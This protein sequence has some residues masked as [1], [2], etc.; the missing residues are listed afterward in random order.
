MGRT[1]DA[2][3]RL[4]LDLCRIRV[5]VET[6]PPLLGAGL[7]FLTAGAVLVAALLALG[8]RTRLRANR[9]EALAAAA[10]GT[11]IL[12]GGIGLL[13][14]AEQEV[15]SGLAALIIASVPWVVVLRL[16]AKQRVTCAT[17]A[18]GLVRRLLEAVD[19]DVAAL[20]RVV[21]RARGVG[22][23]DDLVRVG[24][25]RLASGLATVAQA[26]AEVHGADAV[27]PT[28]SVDVRALPAGLRPADD[29]HDLDR[30]EGDR[31]ERR[32]ILVGEL[33][34]RD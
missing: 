3:C 16:F 8:G 30:V 32:V 19:L 17:L 1:G 2:L 26:D 34:P 14:L 10:V 22:R 33:P 11:L 15:P 13:T 29:G 9:R 18:G 24:A 25:R 31:R 6:V 5:M 28:R 27:D 7:R 12:C 23:G 21:L 4:G 20:E